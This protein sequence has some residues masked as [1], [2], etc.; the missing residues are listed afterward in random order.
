MW[1]L[2]E[3]TEPKLLRHQPVW[4]HSGAHRSSAAVAQC[5]VAG[6]ARDGLW[7]LPSWQL[8]LL[9]CMLTRHLGSHRRG[10]SDSGPE[11]RLAGL[12]W[13]LL[14]G[15]SSGEGSQ[16]PPRCVCCE[17]L[18]WCE[19]WAP[20][21]AFLQDIRPSWGWAAGP[22]SASAGPP[23]PCRPHNWAWP[24]HVWGGRTRGTVNVLT[25]SSWGCFS[26]D[27]SSG[28]LCRR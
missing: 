9:G 24:E 12:C 7:A 1:W 10:S 17:V 25:L 22:C 8:P 2:T 26:Q 15:W 27:W 23:S 3:S 16:L 28:Q 11:P 4:E 20:T 19:A 5:I 13:C 6:S 18:W 14:V 21:G